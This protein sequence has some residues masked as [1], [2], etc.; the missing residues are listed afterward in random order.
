MPAVVPVH[1]GV[2]T[3]QMRA[4][5]LPNKTI[6]EN[7]VAQHNGW[8]STY[9]AVIDPR[10]VNGLDEAITFVLGPRSIQY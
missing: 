2:R 1:D 8:S 6:A 4:K 7:A 9:L 10:A 3:S 5:V